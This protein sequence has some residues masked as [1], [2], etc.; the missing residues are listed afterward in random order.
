M[1][2]SDMYIK[3]SGLRVSNSKVPSSEDI[4]R[5]ILVLTIT[6]YKTLGNVSFISQISGLKYQT[7]HKM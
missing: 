3:Q 1:S 6:K 5:Q 2:T 7:V 4:L